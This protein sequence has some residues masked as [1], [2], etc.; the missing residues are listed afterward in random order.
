MIYS[1]TARRFEDLDPP[2]IARSEVLDEL[3]A[4]V[5]DGKVPLHGGAWAMATMEVC[6]AI[7]DSAQRQ[8]EIR[9]THQ[10]R[11]PA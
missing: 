6:F 5:F 10:C 1:D 11:V 4:A 2:R 3:C 8:T 7:L 9:L